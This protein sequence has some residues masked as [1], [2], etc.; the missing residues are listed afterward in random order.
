MGYTEFCDKVLT[1]FAA[2]ELA[3]TYHQDIHILLGGRFV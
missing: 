1:F 3:A 2:F